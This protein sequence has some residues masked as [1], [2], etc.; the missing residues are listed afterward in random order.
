MID[1]YLVSF[2]QFRK[3]NQNVTTHVYIFENET[4][5]KK[6]ADSLEPIQLA[7]ITTHYVWNSFEFAKRNLNEENAEYEKIGV[8]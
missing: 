6:F 7:K 3:R 1:V 4:E 8:L 2:M 5:A